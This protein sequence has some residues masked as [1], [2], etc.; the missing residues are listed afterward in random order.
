MTL[1]ELLHAEEPQE[2]TIR[3]RHQHDVAVPEEALVW[4]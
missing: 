2:A 3:A 1:E 4:K